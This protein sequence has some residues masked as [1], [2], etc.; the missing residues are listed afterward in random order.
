MFVC[1][2]VVRIC[3]SPWL[4]VCVSTCACVCVCVFVSVFVLLCKFFC[5]VRV[6]VGV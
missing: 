5:C 4:C 6:F 1:I 2:F 3:V